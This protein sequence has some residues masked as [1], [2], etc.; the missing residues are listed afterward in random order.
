MCCGW[1]SGQPNMWIQGAE[2]LSS[3]SSPRRP[4]SGSYGASSGAKI[5]TSTRRPMMIS[6]A[7]PVLRRNSRLPAD[8]QVELGGPMRCPSSAICSMG[9]MVPAWS[10]APEPRISHGSLRSQTE[11]GSRKTEVGRRPGTDSLSDGSRRARN[12]GSSTVGRFGSPPTRRCTAGPF[13]PPGGR[14]GLPSAVCR[15]PSASESELVLI[16]VGSW[17]RGR[18]MRRRLPG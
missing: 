8:R 1:S 10:T 3:P 12:G 11:V 5:A 6:P 9:S 18:R 2:R 4:T 7:T 13:A 15:L 14:M 16:R 17:G